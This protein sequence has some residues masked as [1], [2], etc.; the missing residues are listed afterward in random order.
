MSH[1]IYILSK[2]CE[3]SAEHLQE[4][5]VYG[6]QGGAAALIKYLY[7]T[8]TVPHRINC[9]TAIISVLPILQQ[10]SA[11]PLLSRLIQFFNLVFSS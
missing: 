2:L 4:N 10:R 6:R 5:R 9:S 1:K 7:T 8:S 3:I 11:A